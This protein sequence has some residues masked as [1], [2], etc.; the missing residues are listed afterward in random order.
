MWSAFLLYRYGEALSSVAL[1]AP[2]LTVA[3]RRSTH[4]MARIPLSQVNNQD[5]ATGVCIGEETHHD[6]WYM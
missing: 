5:G 6:C 3:K 4:A 1:Q 2:V